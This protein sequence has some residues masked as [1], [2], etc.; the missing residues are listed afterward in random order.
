MQRGDLSRLV[1]PVEGPDTGRAALSYTTPDRRRSVVFAYQL[2]HPS[3]D[4]PELRLVDLDPATDYRVTEVSLTDDASS[5][6]VLRG[7]QLHDGVP[8]RLDEP[9][10]ARILEIVAVD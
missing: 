4:P 3:S 1:S 8:W 5:D 2:E 10:T 6:S 9:C 7:E